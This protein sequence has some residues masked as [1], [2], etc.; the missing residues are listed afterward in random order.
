MYITVSHSPFLVSIYQYTYEFVRI[1]QSVHIHMSVNT[2]FP[3][4][5]VYFTLHSL[6]L[7]SVC[8]YTYK[9][10]GLFCKRALQKRRYS[11]KET[12]NFMDPTNQA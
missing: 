5:C 9:T 7:V 1:N 3:F 6:F 11:A 10:I 2:K 8:Q 12:Y 4:P